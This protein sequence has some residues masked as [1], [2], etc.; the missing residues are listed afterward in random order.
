[1][2]PLGADAEQDVTG[3]A[4]AARGHAT[5]TPSRD[6]LAASRRCR[7]GSREARFQGTGQNGERESL[8]VSG[9]RVAGGAQSHKRR[10]FSE[11]VNGSTVVAVA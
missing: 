8:T 5:T 11:Q 6:E 4:T 2:F 1:M 7:S 3:N 9:W 10:N